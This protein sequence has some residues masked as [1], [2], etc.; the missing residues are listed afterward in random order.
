MTASGFL[1][2]QLEYFINDVAGCG[3]EDGLLYSDNN[4]GNCSILMLTLITFDLSSTSGN[5]TPV[6]THYF[7]LNEDY[8]IM[9]YRRRCVFRG[10]FWFEVGFLE[11]RGLGKLPSSTYT[12][13]CESHSVVDLETSKF[14]MRYAVLLEHT[15]RHNCFSLSTKRLRV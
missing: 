13:M 9:H 5:A 14:R 15:A 2:Y 4:L 11:P 7:S 10:F 1:N 12:G 3:S 8:T 6:W